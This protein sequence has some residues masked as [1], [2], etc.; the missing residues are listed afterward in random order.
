ML[1]KTASEEGK[2]WDRLVPYLLF[3]YREVPQE[4]TG[5]SPFEMLYGREVHGPLDVLREIWECDK[6]SDLNVVSYIMLIRKR[7]EKMWT[8][9]QQSKE[10]A[11]TCQKAWYD[12]TACERSFQLRDEVLVLLPTSESKL[13]AQY[14][15]PYRMMKPVG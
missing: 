6:W 10:A 4:S 12:K 2:D 1:C 11:Q 3:T 7:L 15:G 13:T 14:R 9:A 8:E 5:F